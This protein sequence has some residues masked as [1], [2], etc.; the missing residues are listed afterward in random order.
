ML[1]H[2]I[3]CD[4]WCDPNSKVIWNVFEKGLKM[5]LK[6][7]KRKLENKSIFKVVKFILESLIELSIFIKWESIFETILELDLNLA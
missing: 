1:L 4:E 5:A 3:N 7:K 2:F 6:R